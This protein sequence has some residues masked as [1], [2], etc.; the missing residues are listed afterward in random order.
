MS[1]LKWNRSDCADGYE[2]TYEEVGEDNPIVPTER[3]QDQTTKTIPSLKPCTTYVARLISFL[4]DKYSEESEKEFSTKPGLD[5][6][7]KIGIIPVSGLNSVTITWPTWENVTCI[8]EYRIK[9]C[10]DNTTCC[11]KEET[12]K[13]EN[14]L[15]LHIRYQV[16]E[17]QP[18]TKYTIRVK[19]IFNDLDI[20][21][22]DFQIQTLRNQNQEHQIEGPK[23]SACP[24]PFEFMKPKQDS[25]QNG[26]E[27]LNVNWTRLTF[28]AFM[29]HLL[30]F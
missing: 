10:K 29:F 14:D 16:K 4:G 22:R 20:T 11:I 18:D 23:D 19:P 5:I 13:K 9:V 21:V 7:S 30:M 8:D 6:G 28:V 1:V 27:S 24:V 15:D 17:L 12:V 26:A 2:I 25:N 3:L